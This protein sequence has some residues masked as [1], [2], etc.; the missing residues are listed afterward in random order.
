[1]RV[2]GTTVDLAGSVSAYGLEKVLAALPVK[3]AE[4]DA[5]LLKHL[6]A[7]EEAP[8]GEARD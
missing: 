4:Q 2:P 1:V 7:R 5:A 8:R 6:K 3:L